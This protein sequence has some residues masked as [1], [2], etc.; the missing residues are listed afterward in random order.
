MKIEADVKNISKLSD[1]YFLVPDYQREYVWKVDDQVEQFIMDLDN[2]YQP[3]QKDQ[4]GYFL[5]SVIIV[6]NGEK[7]DVIDGQQRLTTIVITMCALRDLLKDRL[8]TLDKKGLEYLKTIEEWLSSYDINSEENLI[9]LDLQYEESRGFISRL[10]EGQTNTFAETASVKKMADAY[11]HIRDYLKYQLQDSLNGLI[12]FAR[13]FLTKVELV[14]IESE[15]LSSALKIFETINQRGASLNA[16]DLVKNLIFSQI[17]EEQ[18][19]AIKTT[20]KSITN[21]LESCG[22]SDNPLRF[23]RYFLMARYH[24]GILREDDIYKWIISAEGEL[25]L[26]YKTR[27]MVLVKELEKL[28]ERYANLVNATN[29]AAYWRENIRFPNVSNIGYINKYRS[30]QHLVLLMALDISCSD[31]VMDFLGAQLE[32]FLFFTNTMVIQSKTYE[33]RFTQ[34]AVKLRDV[35]T[36]AEVANVVSATLIPFVVERLDEFKERFSIIND[37]N[38]T[39]QYRQRYVLGRLENH[40]RHLCGFPEKSQQAIQQMQIEH[41]LPQTV[42]N[43]PEN[44]EFSDANR[45]SYLY[46]LGN[47]TL[48]ESTINQSVNNCNDLSEDW[49]LKKQTEYLNSEIIMTR[50]LH[51]QYSIGDNTALNRFKLKYGYEYQDWSAESI[52]ARQRLLM[53]LA[54]DCWRFNDQRIDAYIVNNL[55][56]EPGNEFTL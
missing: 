15:N 42:R 14:V 10:I 17:K 25:S 8:D 16:M 36:K 37:Y 46:K 41:I 24:H 29:E 47:V 53:D 27:P 1:Y 2:E 11:D 48:L 52:T 13:F 51:S 40:I 34:W 4:N 32:S 54:I 35:K 45:T 23:L 38:F 20:W 21:N 5:G 56:T 26:Q 49:F 18:F 43:A 7:H 39:P 28:S 31:D 19:S 44:G 3:E 22:E 30:R 33:Q 9:R 50:L 6:K 55:S 12:S